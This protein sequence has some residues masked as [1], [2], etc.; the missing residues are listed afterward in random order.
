MRFPLSY[1][2]FFAKSHILFF[3]RHHSDFARRSR[4][5]AGGIAFLYDGLICVR[6]HAPITSQ[7][8]H[9]PPRSGEAYIKEE[10]IHIFK[11]Y[12]LIIAVKR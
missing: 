10:R 4:M 1:A 9:F 8:R 3:L 6:Q 7:A 11:K 2:G 12:Y 5:T